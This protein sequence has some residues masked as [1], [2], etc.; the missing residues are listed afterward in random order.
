MVQ[1]AIDFERGKTGAPDRKKDL[2]AAVAWLTKAQEIGGLEGIEYSD[3]TT[4]ADTVPPALQ[5]LKKAIDIEKLPPKE[6]EQAIQAAA[7]E[8]L[9]RKADGGD[10]TS[11][12]NLGIDY[13]NGTDGATENKPMAVKY[14]EMAIAN[15]YN[16]THYNLSIIYSEGT[17]GVAQDMTKC[18]ALRIQGAEAG[19]LSCMVQLA[20]DFEKGKNG[21]PGGRKDIVAAVVWLMKA[22]EIGGL[23]AH[24]YRGGQTAA[25]RVAL[26]I[27]R[28][29]PHAA[30]TASTMLEKIENAKAVAAIAKV[31]RKLYQ[32][33]V[34]NVAI[35][36]N[37]NEPLYQKMKHLA[38]RETRRLVDLGNAAEFNYQG[39]DGYAD[40]LGLKTKALRDVS[41]AIAGFVKAAT[42]ADRHASVTSGV[43]GYGFGDEEEEEGFG[44][45]VTISPGLKTYAELV[46]RDADWALGPLTSLLESVRSSIIKSNGL[47][48]DA[49]QL[50]AGPR[51]ELARF[52][53][54]II[55]YLLEG[56]SRSG[57]AAARRVLDIIRFTFDFTEPQILAEFYHYLL[58]RSNKHVKKLTWIRT[59]NK[60][61][62][63]KT[64]LQ[65]TNVLL[66]FEVAHPDHMDHSIVIEIQLTLH[67]HLRIKKALHLFYQIERS[68]IPSEVIRNDSFREKQAKLAVAL[69]PARFDTAN[70][71]KVFW[72]ADDA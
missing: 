40:V 54:K 18:H 8:E 38:T 43:G 14:Y 36:A 51:K 24:T 71:E 52:E 12:H 15:G 28:L 2:V 6:R 70:R 21:V 59:K 20:E 58:G 60:F 34:A 55:E 37:E 26:T 42:N 9:K 63:G 44:F 30:A 57:F 27:T 61:T 32:K 33:Y 1:L 47:G 25:E 19:S 29:R 64:A 66:N 5:R 67:D 31:Q 4:A 13:F 22:Q 41:P 62:D 10:A 46:V 53:D 50:R 69:S 48:A 72:S 16:K 23:E 68:N 3:G 7:F 11:Q 17:G 35:G 39:Q 65:R 49:A 45:G 56:E